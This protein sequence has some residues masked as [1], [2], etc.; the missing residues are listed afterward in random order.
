MDRRAW[1]VLATTH[2]LVD[3]CEVRGQLTVP[4]AIQLDPQEDVID[5]L[6]DAL[7]LSNIFGGDDKT[8]VVDRWYFWVIIALIAIFVI[9]CGYFTIRGCRRYRRVK[10]E[11][12]LRML[13]PETAEVVYFDEET[14]EYIIEM[15]RRT[16]IPAEKIK[17]DAARHAM[18]GMGK[19]KESTM[20]ADGV[21][22]PRLVDEVSAGELFEHEENA[23]DKMSDTNNGN[24]RS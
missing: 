17:A 12:Q 5:K 8:P 20:M 9:V 21:D 24:E 18:E 11:N 15:S 6:T 7:G 10:K 14:Q 3:V 22:T 2:I 13:I 1:L 23:S 16:G 19:M 4:G